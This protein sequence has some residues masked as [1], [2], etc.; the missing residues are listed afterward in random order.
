MASRC[1]FMPL[2]H[3]IQSGGCCLQ[4]G[5]PA[6]CQERPLNTQEP[7]SE[8]SE[9]SSSSK[10]HSPA[11]FRNHLLQDVVCLSFLF[12]FYFF[13]SGLR[14][15][16][17]KVSSFFCS[18]LRLMEF[19]RKALRRLTRHWLLGHGEFR[20]ARVLDTGHFRNLRAWWYV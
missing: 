10:T 20:V 15:Q 11:G 5:C 19:F 14:L 17:D 8:G 2:Q 13:F 4:A 9:G 18:Q 7:D 6:D 12:L 16:S 3:A 1:W